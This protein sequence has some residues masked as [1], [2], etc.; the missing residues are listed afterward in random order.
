MKY[1]YIGAQ[2]SLYGQYMSF[3]RLKIRLKGKCAYF[4][5]RL[6][7]SHE[8]WVEYFNFGTEVLAASHEEERGFGIN[9]FPGSI[10]LE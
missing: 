2:E 9:N 3:C 10:F 1:A 7:A 8:K 6:V 4:T 5:L